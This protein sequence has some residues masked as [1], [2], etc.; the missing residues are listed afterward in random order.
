MVVPDL[1]RK[2]RRANFQ[3]HAQPRPHPSVPSLTSSRVSLMVVARLVLTPSSN[4]YCRPDPHCCQPSSSTGL[5]LAEFNVEPQLGGTLGPAV[6]SSSA[7]S[8]TSC[9]PNPRPPPPPSSSSPGLSVSSR[10]LH[11]G[12]PA[13]SRSLRHT[14]NA[15]TYFCLYPSK[16]AHSLTL[17]SSLVP[18]SRKPQPR[19]PP[20]TGT[21]PAPSR[22]KSWLAFRRSA[23][24]Q[25][26]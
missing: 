22:L 16:V 23:R 13:P 18:A 1:G 24:D 15:S 10:V 8:S 19:G 14:L 20:T 2:P 4:R 5:N 7:P 17:S 25:S 9:L 11:P 6:N 26:S 3:S 21:G 12:P